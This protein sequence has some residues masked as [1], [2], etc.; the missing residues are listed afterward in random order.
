MPA[1]EHVANQPIVRHALHA[2]ETAGVERVLVASSA[3]VAD[4]VRESLA[5]PMP[6]SRVE[7]QFVERREPLDFASA[8]RFV[9]PVVADSACIVHAAGGL[10]AEPLRP[11]VDSLNNGDPDAVL[12]V[13]QAPSPDQ[14]LSATARSVLHLADLDPGRSALGLAGVWG[15]G[16]G[17]LRS[18]A[19]V[20]GS[21]PGDLD[22]DGR[23]PLDLA[24]LSETISSAGGTLHVRLVDVWQAYRGDAAE[25][26]E[27]NHLVLDQLAPGRTYAEDDNRIEGRVRIHEHARLEGSTIVGPAV[28]GP[29]ARIT[30]AYIGPYTSVGAGAV[31][32]GA[33]ID[34]SII[35]AGATISHVGGRLTASVIGR[36]AR[37]FRDFSLPRALRLRVGDGAELGLS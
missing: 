5:D 27:L 18:A 7:V 25:L 15:F 37:L 29:R 32:E 36:N 20:G 10:L 6:A 35:S 4:A 34:R 31:I 1:V 11:V 8:L 16:P 22:S 30:N 12:M 28:I 2:L 17:V 21:A 14:R 23:L 24:A 33:E 19:A 13:H 26:L 3:R 9:A